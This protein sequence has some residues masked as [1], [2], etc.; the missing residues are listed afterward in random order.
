MA[1]P[2][3]NLDFGDTPTRDA[4]AGHAALDATN[5]EH[6]S[7]LHLLARSGNVEGVGL[8]LQ[9]GADP[10]LRG[11]G[12]CSPLHAVCDAPLDGADEQH[13]RCVAALLA[14]GAD[15]DVRDDAGRS[16]LLAAVERGRLACVACLVERGADFGGDADGR[17]PLHAAAAA[18]PEALALLLAAPGDRRPGGALPASPSTPG[19]TSAAV[20]I[21]EKIRRR[22]VEGIRKADEPRS[23]TKA[24]LTPPRGI[25]IPDPP[26]LSPSD[27]GDD[28]AA[29][30]PYGATSDRWPVDE[31]GEA[32]Y[33]APPADAWVECWTDAGER[34]YYCPATQASEWELP[35][36]A[37]LDATSP[38]APIPEAAEAAPRRA[39][40]RGRDLHAG[41][42]RLDA[43]PRGARGGVAPGPSSTPSRG[44]APPRGRARGRRRGRRREDRR[45]PAPRRSATSGADADARDSRGNTPL[46]AAASAGAAH[47]VGALLRCGADAAAAN[48]NGDT[49]LHLAVWHR[50]E[51]R[52]RRLVDYGAPLAA[53]NKRGRSPRARARAR[54]HR[55][56][57]GK[58]SPRNSAARADA[59]GGGPRR[60]QRPPREARARREVPRVAAAAAVAGDAEPT[61]AVAGRGLRV[62]GEA[63]QGFRDPAPLG[64]RGCSGSRNPLYVSSPTASSP[65]YARA[66]PPGRRRPTRAG[67]ADLRDLSADVLLD[68]DRYRARLSP[69]ASASPPSSCASPVAAGRGAPDLQPRPRARHQRSGPPWAR[70]SPGASSAGPVAR[71][72]AGEAADGRGRGAEEDEGPDA[73]AREALAARDEAEP[74]RVRHGS[75][76]GA[77]P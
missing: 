71:E 55:D 28:G 49:P 62:A 70:R 13:A 50:R 10:N 40:R 20:A 57:A 43:A 2:A 9:H 53:L 65:L 23:P 5:A 24:A 17:T 58:S 30:E 31:R 47:A 54:V 6:N 45:A 34:Y 67:S 60:D 74:P 61:A 63:S 52:C 56:A 36:G 3:R 18:S 35:A 15:G 72:D 38:M 39:R 11:A 46:H 27:D 59:D 12:G 33:V 1:G 48:T 32:V 8:L 73:P 4:P 21:Y 14:A 29:Y 37:A 76:A 22:G 26:T 19:G 69:A 7:P 75:S 51:A 64:R 44:D 66:S 68:M 25:T 16:P 42:A 41:G 77:R